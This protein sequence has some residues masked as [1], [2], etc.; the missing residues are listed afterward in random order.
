MLGFKSET[1]DIQVDLVLVSP[2][3]PQSLPAMGS[4]TCHTLLL[5]WTFSSVAQPNPAQTGVPFP[6]MFL[7]C[8]PTILVTLSLGVLSVASCSSLFSPQLSRLRVTLTLKSLRCPRVWLCAPYIYNKISLRI[9]RNSHVLYIL[10]SFHSVNKIN[11]NSWNHL[12]PCRL[13]ICI[14]ILYNSKD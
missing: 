4:P 5:S 12:I 13:L 14:A 6:Q 1:K 3:V 2:S 10:F 11:Y 8:N 7:L 9:R